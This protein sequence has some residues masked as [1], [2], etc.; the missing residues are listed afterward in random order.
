MNMSVIKKLQ[1]KFGDHF[2]TE[3][4]FREQYC[5]APTGITRSPPDGVV[6]VRNEQDIVDIVT[7]VLLKDCP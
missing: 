1:E 6:I 5:Q 2:H 7:F 4:T 3:P